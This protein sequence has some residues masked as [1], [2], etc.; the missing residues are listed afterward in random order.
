MSLPNINIEVVA[1]EIQKF[2]IFS[3]VVLLIFELHVSLLTEI[4]YDYFF[5]IPAYAHTI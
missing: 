2:F 1:T 3:A 4:I 5:N